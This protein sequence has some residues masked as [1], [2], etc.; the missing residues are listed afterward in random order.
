[1]YNT[2]KA[3]LIVYLKSRMV[4]IYQ[5]RY[6]LYLEISNDIHFNLFSFY[7]QSRAKNDKELI[8]KG[9]SIQQKEKK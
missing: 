4:A 9:F 7:V 3:D 8:P 1:M 2:L 6:L 5:W